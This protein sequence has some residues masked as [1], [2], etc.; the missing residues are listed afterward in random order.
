MERREQEKTPV[1]PFLVAKGTPQE[2]DSIAL[3]LGDNEFINLPQSTMPLRAIDLLI[4]CNYVLGTQFYLGWKYVIRFL[5]ANI[6]KIK[7]ENPRHSSFT[8]QYKAILAS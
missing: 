3:V 4:K 2:I 1:Q 7:L 5:V 8:D 6:Y